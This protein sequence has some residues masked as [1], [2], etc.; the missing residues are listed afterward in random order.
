MLAG[1][2]RLPRRLEMPVVRGGNADG[3]DVRQEM[4]DGIRSGEALEI[5]NAVAGCFLVADCPAAGAAG[6]GGQRDIHE[7][8]ITAI[9]L[10][11]VHLLE[12]RP[13]GLVEDHA[14]ADHSGPEAVLRQVRCSFH[15]DMIGRV[16]AASNR[17][18]DDPFQ[19]HGPIDK[20]N[21]QTVAP[22]EMRPDQD[23]CDASKGSFS[24]DGLTIEGEID[25]E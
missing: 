18:S 12:E 9:H 22:Q 15:A 4:R 20:M 2:K 3:I 21:F 16:R 24:L 11:G 7:A 13:V 14:Q 23:F 10:L 25:Q 8:E 6:N 5:A 19:Q 1:G 17:R